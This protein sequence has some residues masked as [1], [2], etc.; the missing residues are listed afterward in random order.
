MKATNFWTQFNSKAYTQAADAFVALS[1]DEQA[2]ILENLFEHARDAQMPHSISV[3]YRKLHDGKTYDDFH[4]AW[5][6]PESLSSPHELGGRKYH[7]YFPGH[8]RVVSAVNMHD[9]DEVITV[10][11]HWMKDDE[12]EQKFTEVMA[13]EKKAQRGEQIKKVADKVGKA[14]LYKVVGDDNLGD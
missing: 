5:L 12:A 13:L 2:A 8:I 3:L 11:L 1:G 14:G 9:P 7:G 6:P 4:E 10:G